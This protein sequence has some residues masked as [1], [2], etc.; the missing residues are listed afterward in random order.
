MH[1]HYRIL[2]S[3]SFKTP[4][5]RSPPFFTFEFSRKKGLDRFEGRFEATR[6]VLIT[7]HYDDAA[8]E[9]DDGEED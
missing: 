3:F 9:S 6:R 8:A 5:L 1:R 2:K 4:G 7:S